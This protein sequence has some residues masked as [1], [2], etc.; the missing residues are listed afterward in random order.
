ML[1]GSI[2]SPGHNIFPRMSPTSSRSSPSTSPLIKTDEN[3]NNEPS[4]EEDEDERSP[5]RKSK[6]LIKHDRLEHVTNAS[7]YQNMEM[8]KDLLEGNSI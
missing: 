2:F 3:S 1:K 7:N 6:V 4:P 5:K 8:I